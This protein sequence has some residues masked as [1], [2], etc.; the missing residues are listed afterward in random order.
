MKNNIHKASL[1][2]LW[3]AWPIS[4]IIFA[5]WFLVIMDIP[6]FIEIKIVLPIFIIF[7]ISLANYKKLRINS[8]DGPWYIL[9][10]YLII[11]SIFSLITGVEFKSIFQTL[12]V[13][14]W[15]LIN[16][17]VAPSIL[18]NFDTIKTFAL[19]AYF[20]VL[21]FLILGT[22][23]QLY[24]FSDIENLFRSERLVLFFGNPLYLAGILF[25]QIILSILLLSNKLNRLI[26]I[27]LFILSLLCMYLLYLSFG[28]TFILGILIFCFVYVI[29]GS[30]T[31]LTM[32]VH[33]TILL[34][35]GVFT[36]LP[37]LLGMSILDA[38]LNRI[39]SGRILIWDDA[40]KKNLDGLNILF[41][42]S[43]D[44]NYVGSIK[45]GAGDVITQK[46]A[47]TN[48]DNMYIS[49]L[50]KYG[51][52]GISLLFFALFQIYSKLFFRYK[53]FSGE[54]KIFVKM[55]LAFFWSIIVISVFYEA[56]PSVGNV[57]NAILVPIMFAMAAIP[58]ASKGVSNVR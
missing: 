33:L 8:S 28:R 39:S 40:I 2:S 6:Y 16:V 38:D 35:L 31:Q 51:V 37:M 24:I 45:T 46:F 3:L 19:R 44:P 17:I 10:I 32:I 12:S 11:H 14:L 55:V 7:L 4:Q 52:V 47:K 34:S 49:F 48:Y 56:I 29:L 25:N 21:T 1:I 50:I 9:V 27:S 57:I 36:I 30:I 41:G 22:L 23:L 54:K 15:I 42:A 5:A 26:K 53:I 18:Q 43:I 20:V 13:V 58:V